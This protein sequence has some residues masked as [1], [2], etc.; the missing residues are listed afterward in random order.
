[1]LYFF[2]SVLKHQFCEK[3]MRGGGGGGDRK[4]N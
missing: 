3:R 2:V 1:M 4:Q